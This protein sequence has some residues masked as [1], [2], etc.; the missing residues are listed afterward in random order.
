MSEN[1]EEENTNIDPRLSN[2]YKGNLLEVNSVRGYKMNSAYFDTQKRRRCKAKQLSHPY[3]AIEIAKINPHSLK[4]TG[5]RTDLKVMADTGAMYSL[6]T[7]DAIRKLG[8]NAYTL[9]PTNVEI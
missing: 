1:D 3:I 8:I 6:F 4:E 9:K 5:S 7:F 2:N